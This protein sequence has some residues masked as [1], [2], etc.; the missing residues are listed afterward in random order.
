MDKAGAIQVEG[1]V[2]YAK[3]R[4]KHRGYCSIRKKKVL[5][6]P[7]QADGQIIYFFPGAIPPGN[8]SSWER[9]DSA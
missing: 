5:V 3:V 1:M 2:R 6:G 8:D 7:G 4:G 9:V